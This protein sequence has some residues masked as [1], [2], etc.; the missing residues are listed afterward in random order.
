MLVHERDR[1]P[2]GE[3]HPRRLR[4]ASSSAARSRMRS[5]SVIVCQ[6]VPRR[7]PVLRTRPAVSNSRSSPRMW[8]RFSPVFSASADVVS[9]PFSDSRDSTRSAGMAFNARLARARDVARAL[10]RDR[11]AD[12]AAAA[13][14][15]PLVDS[16]GAFRELAR[17]ADL[18]RLVTLAGGRL[19]GPLSRPS[20]ATRAASNVLIWS[21]SSRSRLSMDSTI[22][23][24]VLMPRDATQAR[25]AS[26]DAAR[27]RSSRGA[28]GR[29]PRPFALA[30]A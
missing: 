22:S 29:R 28:R 5:S 4:V 1:Q 2:A 15:A 20:S 27:P 11:G 12:S 24:V 6:R 9:P 14:K 3:P 7:C 23:L 8:S 26:T 25:G 10:V 16:E 21:S 19:D 18:R 30:H 17:E 13:A